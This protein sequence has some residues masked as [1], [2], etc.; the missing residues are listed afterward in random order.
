[1]FTKFTIKSNLNWYKLSKLTD[2]Y[3][4]IDIGHEYHGHP[5]ILW[6]IDKHGE[7]YTSTLETQSEFDNCDHAAVGHIEHQVSSG[8]YE[9]E[10][11][12]TSAS[13]RSPFDNGKSIREWISEI[14]RENFGSNIR[15]VWC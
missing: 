6:K 14:L 15:I 13:I 11:N 3:T 7:I 1:M 5:V 9:T 12:R 4:Y 2:P 8:R 10:T